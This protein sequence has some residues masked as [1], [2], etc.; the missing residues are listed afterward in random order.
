MWLQEKRVT[1]VLRLT[2]DESHTSGGAM[3]M[4]EPESRSAAER[5]A[6][7]YPY[8]HVRDANWLKGTLL[9]FQQV[10]R[11]V[12]NRFTVKDGA[13]IKPYAELEGPAGPLLAP[14]FVQAP[15]IEA[16]QQWLRS[17]I[18][19]HLDEI[20][21]KYA[22]DK[23]P[24]QFQSGPQAYEMHVDKFLDQE[25]LGLLR[26]KDLAW[27]SRE[28]SEPDSYAWVTMHPTLGSAMMS[29]LA[30]AVARIKGLSV[31]TPSE[32]AHFGLLANREEQVFEKLLDMPLAPGED[33]SSDVTVEELAHVIF[34]IGFD[35]T[36]LTPEQVRELLKE[37]KD[38]RKFRAAISEFSNRIPLGLDREEREKRLKT[39]AQNVLD[40]WA[41]YTR[42]LPTF[43]KESL[44]AVLDKA[45]E[46]LKIGAGATLSTTIGA[47]PGLLITAVVKAGVNMFSRRDTPL[48]FLTRV[49][50]VVDKS[51]GSVYVPQW[52]ALMAQQM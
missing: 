38:L 19:A 29:V 36:R 25:L 26:S 35:L 22:L 28:P 44:H 43:A 9:A 12:P 46:A 20:S 16:S 49:D 8:I 4:Q 7:Y 41:S 10:R 3:A 30:L 6:L 48:R 45:P 33:V 21:A 31:V 24:P 39:E 13:A 5:H 51:I 1:E 23:V 2:R 40:E 47:V 52:R 32:T 34:T 18:T 42:T 11:I 50:K 14:I 27:Q 15:E 37:G 17:R